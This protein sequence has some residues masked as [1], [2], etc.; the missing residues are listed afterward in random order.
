MEKDIQL[1]RTRY[2][3]VV[4][5]YREPVESSTTATKKIVGRRIELRRLLDLYDAAATGSRRLALVSGTAGIGKTTL[6][7][8]AAERAA[9]R[10]ATVLTGS[11]RPDPRPESAVAPNLEHP[12][13]LLDPHASPLASSPAD[14]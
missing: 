1:V 13:P 2:G 11:C 10:G 8:A 7:A 14:G 4:L 12:L 6:A 5:A 9:Q 3:F